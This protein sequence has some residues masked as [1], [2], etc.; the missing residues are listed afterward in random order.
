MSQ[1]SSPIS[2]QVI[3]IDWDYLNAETERKVSHILG[4]TCSKKPRCPN[5]SNVDNVVKNGTYPVKASGGKRRQRYRCQACSCSLVPTMHSPFYASKLPQGFMCLV[6]ELVFS[7]NMTLHAV[8][9]VLDKRIGTVLKWFWY[10]CYLLGRGRVQLNKDILSELLSRGEEYEHNP[11]GNG[12]CQ[13][14]E[15]YRWFKLP[16]CLVPAKKLVV[17][18]GFVCQRL[19][20]V[21]IW[22]LWERRPTTQ[23]IADF[24]LRAP[25]HLG[26]RPREIWTDGAAFYKRLPD[27]AFPHENVVHKLGFCIDGIQ[28]TMQR[29]SGV[30]FSMPWQYTGASK[31]RGTWNC[32][33]WLGRLFRTVA[34]IPIC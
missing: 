31:P 21:F 11:E 22:V 26:F 4:M 12:C 7:L 8:S 27:F 3:K 28:A 32:L 34:A 29:T 15:A 25:K 9:V 2:P 18:L 10:G 23:L 24:L 6:M 17:F 1:Y 19:R 13:I 33:S 5:C 14:D 16:K 30:V 20:R